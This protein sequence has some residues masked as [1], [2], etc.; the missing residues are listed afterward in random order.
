MHRIVIEPSLVRKLRKLRARDRRQ[1]QAVLAKALEIAQAPHRYKN[2]RRPQQDQKS[3]SGMVFAN[4]P[5]GVEIAHTS[6]S[7]D[8]WLT[9]PHGP[10]GPTEGE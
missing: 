4:C 8:G 3:A 10:L 6:T 9:T 2:L 5:R 1:W 7:F